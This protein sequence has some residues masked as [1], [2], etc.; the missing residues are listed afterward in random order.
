MKENN[1]IIL[2]GLNLWRE[3]WSLRFVIIL[4]TISSS[5]G[6]V[7]YAAK[8]HVTFESVIELQIA[9]LPKISKAL[10]KDH[11]YMQFFRVKNWT[12]GNYVTLLQNPTLMY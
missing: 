9:G 4:C 10:I 11:F 5:I 12:R 6:G 1:I 3:I 8:S 7:F 2:D